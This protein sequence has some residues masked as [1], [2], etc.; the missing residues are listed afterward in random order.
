MYTPVSDSSWTLLT[1]IAS[2]IADLGNFG[3]SIDQDAATGDIIIG[4]D[5]FNLYTGQVYVYSFFDSDHVSWSL[6]GVL[7][8]PEGKSHGFG[9]SVAISG[10]YSIVGNT[11][12]HGMSF[13][14]LFSHC[15]IFL[16]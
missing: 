11:K 5:A 8:S 14:C 4:A 15:L 10:N 1:T 3:C 7:V 12:D 2:P 16:L 6:N 13:P 9:A